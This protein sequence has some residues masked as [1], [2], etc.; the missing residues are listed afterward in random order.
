[1][2]LELYDIESLLEVGEIPVGVEEYLNGIITKSDTAK[3]NEDGNRDKAQDL[4]EKTKQVKDEKAR[5]L[6][7]EARRLFDEERK[8]A[9]VREILESILREFPT[10]S[11]RYSVETL[12]QEVNRR[13][14]KTNP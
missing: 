9:E 14:P 12:L 2:A 10:T 7:N 4:L 11:E 3:A 1:M 8:Y 5:A 6:L 13:L